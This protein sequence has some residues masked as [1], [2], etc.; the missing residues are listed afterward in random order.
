MQAE[1]RR[2]HLADEGAA[3]QRTGVPGTAWLCF[4]FLMQNR[5]SNVKSL[6]PDVNGL[7]RRRENVPFVMWSPQTFLKAMESFLQMKSHV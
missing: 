5:F 4:R 3:C 7:H 2:G 6:K 1:P